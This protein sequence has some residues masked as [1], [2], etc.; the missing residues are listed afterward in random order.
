MIQTLA[1]PLL[2]DSEIVVA[3]G[4][5]SGFAAALAAARNGGKVLLLEQTTMLGG[6]GTAGLVP[7]F[8]PTSDGERMI[9]G[10][11]FEEINLEMCRRMG[12]EPWR[13]HWQAIN[14][15]ILKRL[16]DEMAEAAGIRF[17]F[18]AK[19]CEAEVEDGRIRAVLVATSMGLKRVTGRVFIDGTGDAL[20]AALAGT[21][22]EFGDGNGRTMSP[23]LC[24]QFSNIDFPAVHAAGRAGATDREIWKKMTEAG[25]APFKEY[26]FVCMKQVAKASASGNLGHIYGIDTLD[27]FELTRGYVEGRKIAKMLEEFYRGHVPGFQGAE[28]LA[29]ASL[30]GVRETR[31]ILGEYRMTV[32]DYENRAVF[33]D[34][35]GRCCYPVDIHSGSTDAEEQ[36]KVEQVLH[37]TRF[38]HGESYGIPYRA[39]I[40][41]GLANLLVPGRALS[42]DRAIQSSLRVMPPCFVTGQAAGVAAVLAKADFRDVNV[43]E[44]RS[45]LREMGA[46]FK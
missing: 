28:L 12:V 9:Y 17:V 30:L 8:A 41:Q 44:M 14:P 16:L 42:A 27:E 13:D 35:I 24:T 4:G 18:G 22:F 40:P 26:H 25:T 45:R 36:K 29:T 10:G 37:R 3:G 46:Y 2:A 32:A 34:E 21:G 11:I 23:T 39:M 6:L 19:V 15:E 20:L 5:P 33:D 38:K 1:L 31:R 7:M 43:T